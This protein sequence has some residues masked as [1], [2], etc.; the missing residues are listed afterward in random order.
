LTAPTGGPLANELLKIASRDPR[1]IVGLMSGT[2]HDGIDAAVVEVS[3]SG[4]ALAVELVR[5]DCVP[6]PPVVG[7]RIGRAVELGVPELARLSFDLGEAFA[8]A[9]L[10]VI[11]RAGL[12][13]RDVDVIGSHGQTVFHDPPSED[14]GGVTLQIGEA[15]VI[16]RRTGVVTVS[17]F[18][19]ADV[20]AGGS[21]APLIPLVDWLLF[22]RPAGS[23][24]M[25]NVGGIANVTLVGESLGSLIAFDTGPGNA[26]VDE[27]VRMATGGREAFDR[28]GS[29]ASK[30]AVE[31][32]AVESFLRRPYFCKPPP[33]STGKELFGTEAAVELAGLVAGETPISELSEARLCDVLATAVMVTAR[34]VRDAS[35]ALAEQA[36]EVVVSGGGVRNATLMR[37]L[38][39]LFAPTPVVSLAEIGMDPDAKEAVGFA[40]LANETIAGRAGNVPAATGANAPAILGKISPV[41]RE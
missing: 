29:R 19:T 10:E 7:E 39:E 35:S 21:G 37:C 30:G 26:L 23:R 40:V 2:S 6:F 20:A 13:S 36:A 5:F 38:R 28:D 12:T 11:R 18:R 31:D 41:T 15:D 17:D 16:A 22:R 25:L 1:T 8:S 9:A 33:K 34:S 3:G 24:L 14:R 32:A 4:E 27:I